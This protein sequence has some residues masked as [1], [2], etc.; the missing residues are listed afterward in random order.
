MQETE[1]NNSFNE[2]IKCCPHGESNPQCP[3]EFFRGINRKD[4][5][6]TEICSVQ[7]KQLMLDYHRTCNKIRTREWQKEI[8]RAV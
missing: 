7:S 8:S 2:L 6:I 3:F 1:I 5:D 4:L